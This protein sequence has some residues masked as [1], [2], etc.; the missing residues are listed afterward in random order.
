MKT[1]KLF[2]NYGCLAA[3]K[4][5]IYTYGQETETAVGAEEITVV[6]PE[7]WETYETVSGNLAITAPNG[8]DYLINELLSGNEY[9]H[10]SYYDGE[11]FK[12]VKLQV[13]C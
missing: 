2:K 7:G 5:I 3:E 12:K 1:I 8:E 11:K 13:I 10:F 9:P 6:I 4:R